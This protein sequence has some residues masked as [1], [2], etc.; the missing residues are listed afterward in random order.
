MDNPNAVS[1][2]VKTIL[3]HGL[4]LS[5]VD[6]A[7]LQRKTTR[8]GPSLMEVDWGE[9]IDPNYTSSGCMLMQVDGGGKLRVNHINECMPSEV[10]QGAHE[11][12]EDGH[13]IT[14]VD[15]EIMIQLF[16]LWMDAYSL[17]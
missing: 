11:T 15:W 1:N 6:L 10:D 2:Y 14:K 12:H 7:D 5:E 4:S 9:N 17:K 8:H 13:S 16:T 3:N